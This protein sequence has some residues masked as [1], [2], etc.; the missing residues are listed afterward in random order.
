M[1]RNE[2]EGMKHTSSDLAGRPGSGAGLE[3]RLL[4]PLSAEFAAWN[5]SGRCEPTHA[6]WTAVALG[7]ISL[8]ALFWPESQCEGVSGSPVRARTP[9]GC[10]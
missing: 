8:Q 4:L 7:W 10:T 3:L 5:S 1:F 6:V 9:I 2:V